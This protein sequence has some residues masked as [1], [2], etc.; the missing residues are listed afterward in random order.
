MIRTSWLAALIA[1]LFAI[2]ASK[3]A[4]AQP[5]TLQSIQRFQRLTLADGLPQLSIYAI[6]QDKQGF[7]WFGT[8]DGL[9]RFDGYDFKVFQASSKENKHSTVPSSAITALAHDGEDSL[10]I[11]TGDGG[12]A[13]FKTSTQ[14]FEHFQHDPED[15]KTISSNS[16]TTLHLDAAGRL[17]IGTKEGLDRR[18]PGSPGF[19]RYGGG[20]NRPNEPS[21]ASVLAIS[22]FGENEVWI[23]STDGLD[24]LNTQTDQF[25][26]FGRSGRTQLSGQ[27]ISALLALKD[28]VWIGTDGF[29]LNV[30][31]R[32]E[33]IVQQFRQSNNDARSLSDDRIRALFKDRAGRLWV[34][35]QSGLNRL[36]RG[37]RFFRYQSRARDSDSLPYPWIA[38]IFEDSGNVLW[39]GTW[40]G[41]VGKLDLRSLEVELYP[42][43]STFAFEYGP[44]K[45]VWIGDH[46]GGLS[47]FSRGTNKVTTYR[48]AGG[49]EVAIHALERSSNGNIWVGTFGEG[50]RK[51]SPRKSS[52]QQYK[53]MPGE[54]GA[55]GSDVIFSLYEDKNDLWIGTWGGGLNKLETESEWFF[56]YSTAG[57]DPDSISSNYV[58]TVKP[59]KKDKNILWIGT[60]GGGLNRFDKKSEVFKSYVHDAK[61]LNSLS[62]NNVLCI[63]ED[64]QHRFWLGTYGGG[65]NLFD[66]VNE[67]FERFGTE[68]GLPHHFVFGIV[69]DEAGYLWVSTNK[70]IARFDPKS[71]TFDTFGINDG[72]QGEEFSQGAYL[73]I[74]A[75]KNTDVASELIF[76]GVQGFNIF[77]PTALRPDPFI[78][79]VVMT[80]LEISGEPVRFEKP[81]AK[82]EKIQLRYDQPLV[83]VEFAA[84]SFASPK[85][86][87]YAYR[88]KGFQDE[89]IETN[90]RFMSYSNLTPGQYTFQVKGSNQHGVWNKAGA[91]LLLEVEPPPWRTWWAYAIYTCIV[92]AI[93]YSIYRY[94]EQRVA[95]LQAASQ[96]EA[97]EKDLELA[98]TV[99]SLFLPEQTRVQEMGFELQGFFR[100]ASQ[101]SGDWWGYERLTTNQFWVAVGDVTGHG[102]GPA[103]LTASVATA[104]QVQR[105]EGSSNVPARLT[106]LSTGIREICQGQYHMTMSTL[107]LDEA[108]GKARFYGTGGLPIFCLLPDGS[109]RQFG[110]PGTP[111]GVESFKLGEASYE[112]TPGERLWVFSDGIPEM[113][114]EGGRAIGIR[115]CQRILANTKGLSIEEATQSIVSEVDQLRFG[116][117][118][119]DMTFVLLDWKGSRAH[120]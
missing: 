27:R 77:K 11:G 80:N 93:I 57:F 116:E 99:Q 45:T 62:H 20:Q 86:N 26:R 101:C 111:L 47:K 81:I 56:Q 29:G 18:D 68:D 55:L 107:V 109:V 102:A 44:R 69:E 115:R 37:Q 28:E 30:F 72:L 19:Q 119:D 49:A 5:Q 3:P 15:P 112:L 4:V 52:F 79:P 104:L 31:K 74:P 50:L 23:G 35:T 32:K 90:R 53:A 43:D 98:S 24:K 17:W 89:W 113:A 65:L 51:F 71:R 39:V 14:R 95:R 63:H 91:E 48:A 87:Q 114:M 6:A 76:G 13:R 105:T 1:G 83:A 108:G 46:K 106:Q 2:G 67:T 33:G 100:P 21:G 94:Q 118:E 103:V 84:L 66:P 16:V 73:G 54:P 70:G 120:F 8:G 40:G 64:G 96:L 92:I 9:A 12:L 60:A 82:I 75:S 38:S 36:T 110:A 41:G 7:V 58:Y 59:D 78:P 85:R 117:Q 10:W 25:T 61:D 22:S 97:A 88:L 34:G 42:F